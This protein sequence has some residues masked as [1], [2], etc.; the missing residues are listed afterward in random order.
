MSKKR[1]SKDL[2]IALQ[3]E[4]LGEASLRTALLLTLNPLRKTKVE[5]MWR[6]EA[7]TK[8]R[9]LEYFSVNNIEI[10]V[11]GWVVFKGV[12]LGILFPLSPWPAV[13]RNTLKETDYYLQVF[14]RLAQ[15]APE[16]DKELFEYI[17]AHEEA[18]KRFAELESEN[19]VAE[20]LQPINEL[21]AE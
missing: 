15:Q 9:I 4:T 1:P 5:A 3:C 16:E 8:T 7:Q 6:L 13:L 17:V 2:L 18:I 19:R 10:P 20:S 21:L 12:I 14:Y 11:L